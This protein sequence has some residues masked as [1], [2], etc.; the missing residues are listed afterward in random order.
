MLKKTWIIVANS[1]CARI[2][3]MEKGKGDLKELEALV[4]PESRLREHDLVSDKPGRGYE[5]FGM[6]RHA[7]EPKTSAKRQEFIDFAKHLTRHLESARKKGEFECLFVAATPVFL[8]VLRQALDKNTAQLIEREIDK[9]I[10]HLTPEE[11]S[12]YFPAY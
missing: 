12:K 1:N 9:D 2:F 7:I 4:H 11:I 10:I 8:G 6:E 3:Q 5:S